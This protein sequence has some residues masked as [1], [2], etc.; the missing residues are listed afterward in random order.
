MAREEE[1]LQLEV[2]SVIV[3][4]LLLVCEQCLQQLQR[5]TRRTISYRNLLSFMLHQARQDL[6]IAA[7]TSLLCV[8]VSILFKKKR[9]F[10]G[11][12]DTFCRS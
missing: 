3:K 8:C 12:E 4:K 2:E 5:Q 11:S 7:A 10:L 9:S 6:L 1:A